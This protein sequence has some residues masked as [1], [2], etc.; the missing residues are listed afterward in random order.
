MQLEGDYGSEAVYRISAVDSG[1]RITPVRRSK[2]M[3]GT[4]VKGSKAA[5]SGS[6]GTGGATMRVPLPSGL[7]LGGLGSVSIEAAPGLR[8]ELE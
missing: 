4:P 7:A 2:R 3:S 1:V 8:V 5:T 6:T